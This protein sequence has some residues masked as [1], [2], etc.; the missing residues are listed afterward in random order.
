MTNRLRSG[1]AV[2]GLDGAWD[3]IGGGMGMCVLASFGPEF[4]PLTR[5]DIGDIQRAYLN[6]RLRTEAEKKAAVAAIVGTASHPR[7][8][9]STVHRCAD[10]LRALGFVD[11][12]DSFECR[13][14][15][16]KAEQK[17][18]ASRL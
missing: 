1:Q 11:Q 18:D 2:S 9:P 3:E 4:W 13:A 8:K 10:A 12:A 17:A 6:G 5:T 15:E 16:L 7:A 14:D